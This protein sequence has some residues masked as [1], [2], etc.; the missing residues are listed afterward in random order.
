LLKV[1]ALLQLGL[2]IFRL[3]IEQASWP[4]VS[5]SIAGALLMIFC[6]PEIVNDERVEHLKLKGAK[7]GLLVGTLVVM[8]TQLGATMAKRGP[9][10]P[11][12]SG[13]PPTR[14]PLSAFDALSLVLLITLGCYYYWRWQDGRA[15]AAS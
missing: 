2:A 11:S 15:E 12:G 5:M 13:L 14:L 10:Q 4:S 3:V 9:A 8:L 6:A 1:L 7:A